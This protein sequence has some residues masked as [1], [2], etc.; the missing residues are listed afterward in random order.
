MVS[1]RLESPLDVIQRAELSTKTR[2]KR[3]LTLHA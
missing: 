2:C 3:H 1:T